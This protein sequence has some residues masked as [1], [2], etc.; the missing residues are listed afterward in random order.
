MG[1]IGS[2]CGALGTGLAYTWVNSLSGVG[3]GSRRRIRR[4]HRPGR[5]RRA[6][7]GFPCQG[8]RA[9]GRCRGEGQRHRPPCARLRGHVAGAPAGERLLVATR[10]CATT[11]ST[12]VSRSPSRT[13]LIVPVIRDADREGLAEV[14]TEAR[15]LAER[16]RAFQTSSP[17]GRSRSAISA[18]TA[19][20]T[21][22]R[23]STRR[24]RPS[25][26]SVPPPRKPSSAPAGVVGRAT[27][28]LTM[29]VDHR[30][31]DGATG[32]ALLRDLKA[33]LEAPL[34]IVV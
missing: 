28:K 3:S 17:V 6:A 29:S 27:L 10:S 23:S 9:T 14:A 24:R 22:P 21:S 11:G 26:R 4:P 8:Q 25:S 33:A 12:S 5:R 18:C 2:W 34:R 31:L 7:A 13:G 30:V 19:S 15:S 20:T 1:S 32:A 16:D